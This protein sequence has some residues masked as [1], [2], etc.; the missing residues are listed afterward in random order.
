MTTAQIKQMLDACY[1][2]KRARELLP[3]LPQGVMPS[4]IQFL[5]VITTLERRGV[6]PKI[7]DIGDALALPRP[8]VTRTVKEME[9][10]GYLAKTASPA[11]GRVTYLSVTEAGRAL[12]KK[13]DETY[14][15]DFAPAFAD[16]PEADVETTI[17]TIDA[18]Y[19]AMQERRIPHENR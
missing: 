4:Y 12:H 2:A 6:Q 10:K 14:F 16:I 7:S 18:F 3:P 8:G 1:R 5:D 13:Y 15:A 17:R 11:D 9:A 19:H